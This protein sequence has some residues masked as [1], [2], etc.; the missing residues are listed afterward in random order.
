M[1]SRRVRRGAGDGRKQSQPPRP[2]LLDVIQTVPRPEL[3][4]LGAPPA[5]S[6]AVVDLSPGAAGVVVLRA[7]QLQY[8]SCLVCPRS[9]HHRRAHAIRGHPCPQFE[10][11]DWSS[12]LRSVNHLELMHFMCGYPKWVWQESE[13]AAAPPVNTFEANRIRIQGLLTEAARW[14]D[15]LIGAGG[16]GFGSVGRADF[17]HYA[18]AFSEATNRPS[19]GDAR[20]DIAVITG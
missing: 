6:G 4:T 19:P 10:E 2:V 16:G 12:P 7:D 15:R 8:V 18:A 9:L 13:R 11:H 5:D 14:A 1:I 17:M 20:G 3:F